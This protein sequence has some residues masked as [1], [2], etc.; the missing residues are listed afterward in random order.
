MTL[1]GHARAPKPPPSPDTEASQSSATFVQQES[2]DVVTNTSYPTLNDTI[3]I[4]RAG[5]YDITLSISYLL[6]LII[7]CCVAF[8]MDGCSDIDINLLVKISTHDE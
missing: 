7:L 8:S 4:I 2:T 5:Y 1:R 3:D 6:L